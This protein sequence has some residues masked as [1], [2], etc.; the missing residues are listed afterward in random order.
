MPIWADKAIPIESVSS[1][2]S[3]SEGRNTLLGVNWS[4]QPS[5]MFKLKA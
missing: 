1:V 3:Q 4:S 2:L 5:A